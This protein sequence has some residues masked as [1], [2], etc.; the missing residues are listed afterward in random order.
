MGR[1]LFLNH[2]DHFVLSSLHLTAPS[3]HFIHL[4]SLRCSGMHGKVTAALVDRQ[5]QQRAT[6][7]RA[8]SCPRMPTSL[9]TLS[10]RASSMASASACRPR[11]A[12][13]SAAVLSPTMAYFP[14]ELTYACPSKR[15]ACSDVFMTSSHSTRACDGML[16]LALYAL[17][18][19]T[20]TPHMCP[21]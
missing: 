3:H 20:D 11:S 21:H 5:P 1:L 19:S 7:A 2:M 4:T 8:R 10:W 18:V 17:R 6:Q 14:A 16:M 13:R 15:R 12:T 9:Q